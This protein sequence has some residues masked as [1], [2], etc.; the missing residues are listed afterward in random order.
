LPST[1]TVGVILIHLCHRNELA[2]IILTSIE[3][4]YIL[5]VNGEG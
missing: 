1:S 3:D 5:E 4:T 2:I